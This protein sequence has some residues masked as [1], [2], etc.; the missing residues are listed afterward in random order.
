MTKDPKGNPSGFGAMAPQRG[1]AAGPKRPPQPVVPTMH[2]PQR[3]TTYALSDLDDAVVPT[4]APTVKGPAAM[5]I[6]EADLL[7][8][9]PGTL[10]ASEIFGPGVAAALGGPAA[11]PVSGPGLQTMHTMINQPSQ[12]VA[13][14]QASQT[15]DGKAAPGPQ[16][17]VA[18]MAMG[19]GGTGRQRHP[20]V[21]RLPHEEVLVEVIATTPTI[22]SPL[23]VV[24]HEPDGEPAAAYRV[25]GHRLTQPMGMRTILVTSAE[26]GD[27]KSVCAA[28]IALAMSEYGRATVLLVE[29][30]LR[31]P[32]LASL[33]GFK[34]PKCFSEQLRAH[35]KEPMGS[36]TM[37]KLSTWLHVLAVDPAN[38]KRPEIIDALSIELAVEHF[39][40][41]PYDFIFIDTPSV[42]GQADVP[43][44][45]DCADGIVLAAL[46]RESH[47]AAI[48]Q[49]M[50]ML[51]PAPILG[52]ALLEG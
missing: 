12:L 30:N 35:K 26:D 13:M 46:A 9:S 23:L 1:G 19:V 16:V 50:Q 36:W 43:L 40:R 17:A 48:R 51:A 20:A 11:P 21:R 37:A 8:V 24:S 39:K 2:D 52:I 15:P 31:A 10:K 29:A 44:M 41:L 6:A 28:N 27:G 22:A 4:D 7:T 14:A 38:F 34:P 32:S 45:Q 47:G 25:L 42:L 3:T 33:L 49:A 5:E 18:A